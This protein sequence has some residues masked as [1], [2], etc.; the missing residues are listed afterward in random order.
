MWK[1]LD[2]AEDVLPV[3]DDCPNVLLLDVLSQEEMR[4]FKIN[5]PV[6]VTTIDPPVPYVA[7]SYA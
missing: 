4:A 1:V 5:P 6:L 3:S 7:D 2:T